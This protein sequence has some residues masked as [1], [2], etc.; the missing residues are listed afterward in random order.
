MRSV[1]RPGTGWAAELVHVARPWPPPERPTLCPA[2][3][4]LVLASRVGASLRVMVTGFAIPW[5]PKSRQRLGFLVAAKSNLRAAA[6]WLALPMGARKVCGHSLTAVR[7][8]ALA[9]SA[10]ETADGILVIVAIRLAVTYR[11]V[12][13]SL[14]LAVALGAVSAPALLHQFRNWQP[15][16]AE[17]P[18]FPVDIAATEDT[19]NSTWTVLPSPASV[20]LHHQTQ[21]LYLTQ[22]VDSLTNNYTQSSTA[23]SVSRS[24][25]RSAPTIFCNHSLWCT[26]LQAL[27]AVGFLALLACRHRLVPPAT[28]AAAATIKT[29]LHVAVVEVEVLLQRV[30]LASPGRCRSGDVASLVALTVAFYFCFVELKTCFVFVVFSAYGPAAPDF[31]ECGPSLPAFSGRPAAL[32][33]RWLGA[34]GLTTLLLAD[35]AAC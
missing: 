19:A 33:W 12:L 9:R 32:A 18:P 11:P 13:Q 1:L 30:S 20:K 10:L 26:L 4:L 35:L 28:P 7:V 16:A 17:S 15:P 25:S 34:C 6:C 2:A 29:E 31:A 21:K 27:A 5:L 22:T 8:L 14:H 3:C 23:S 24:H